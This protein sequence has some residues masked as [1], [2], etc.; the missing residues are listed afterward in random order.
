MALHHRWG[1]TRSIRQWSQQKLQVPK[2]EVLNLIRLFWGWVLPYISL[3]YSLSKVSTSILG[4]W[5][6]WWWRVQKN[7]GC[8]FGSCRLQV[9]SRLQPFPAIKWPLRLHFLVLQEHLD[10]QAHSCAGCASTSHL[11]FGTSHRVPTKNVGTL[12]CL[13][14]HFVVFAVQ[15]QCSPLWCQGTNF[16]QFWMQCLNLHGEDTEMLVCTVD[17]IKDVKDADKTLRPVNLG[18]SSWVSKWRTSCGSGQ[19]YIVM[20]FW[21]SEFLYFSKCQCDEKNMQL[22]CVE[23]RV[24]QAI[25]SLLWF[26]ALACH[27][28]G[29]SLDG[30]CFRKPLVPK[31]TNILNPWNY[32]N[33]HPLPSLQIVLKINQTDSTMAVPKTSMLEPRLCRMRSKQSRRSWK[34]LQKPGVSSFDKSHE[35]FKLQVP[36]FVKIMPLK[37]HFRWH[38]VTWR[39]PSNACRSFLCASGLHILW[40]IFK[41]SRSQ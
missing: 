14:R 35:Y 9:V 30:V 11:N 19:L 20:T 23:A 37:R 39:F 28:A 32:I 24:L 31:Q 38:P 5:N 13:I 8:T 22:L 4:T 41:K 21:K 6:V 26:V 1:G 16:H 33:Y 18:R 3:T 25:G 29:S 40:S 17:N 10:T 27:P 36:K 7:S 15:K 2:M 34:L 12:V